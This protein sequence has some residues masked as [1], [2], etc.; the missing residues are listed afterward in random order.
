[1]VELL[2]RCPGTDVDRKFENRTALDLAEMA[3]HEKIAKL[4]ASEQ[5]RQQLISTS[6]TSCTER[7]G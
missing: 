4:L 3:G 6:G 5:S 7:E 1:M 2:L